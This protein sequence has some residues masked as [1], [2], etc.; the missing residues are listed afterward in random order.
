MSIPDFDVSSP[1]ATVKGT[2]VP[3]FN[4]SCVNRI[5][6]GFR[7]C[8]LQEKTGN[9]SMYSPIYLSGWESWMHNSSIGNSTTCMMSQIF[10]S[11][12]KYVHESPRTCF[13]I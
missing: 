10:Y 13:E 2:L 12:Q 11:P 8:E 5:M 1:S 7:K 6:D 3:S 9:D 4:V